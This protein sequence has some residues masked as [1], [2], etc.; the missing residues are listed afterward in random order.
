ME[1]LREQFQAAEH[2]YDHWKKV[3][4]AVRN[5]LSSHNRSDMSP[6]H[7]LS[8]ERR[9][10]EANVLKQVSRRS[11]ELSD[12]MCTRCDTEMERTHRTDSLLLTEQATL[13][14][15]LKELSEISDNLVQG[16][17]MR[18]NYD[19]QLVDDFNVI[20]ELMLTV[21]SLEKELGTE[22]RFQNK[23]DK[24]SNIPRSNRPKQVVSDAAAEMQDRVSD[25]SHQ[26]NSIEEFYAKEHA[27]LQNQL[28]RTK[29]NKR[30]A[31]TKF[32]ADIKS[33][34]TDFDFLR[35]RLGRAENGLEK[36]NLHYTLDEEELVNIIAPLVENI[37][38]IRAQIDILEQEVDAYFYR[39]EDIAI[40]GTINDE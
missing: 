12:M 24:I 6:S 20:V 23:T 14:V 10:K 39:E 35:E 15:Q 4:D 2:E 11:M 28:T 1:V 18:G 31:K 9:S 32:Q 36:V 3:C 8:L 5:R 13:S 30:S 19:Y 34:F 22:K 29:L 27:S 16:N 26:L 7:T 38:A 33:L 25:L 40:E 21:D 17:K 37:D